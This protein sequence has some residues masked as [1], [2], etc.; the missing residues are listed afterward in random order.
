MQIV[1]HLDHLTLQHLLHFNVLLPQYKAVKELVFSL[2]GPLLLHYCLFS[3]HFH[4]IPTLHH[5]VHFSLKFLCYH[6]HLLE[7][8]FPP[9]V[10]CIPQ[11]VLIQNY[12][13]FF[14]SFT[15]VFTLVCLSTCFSYLVKDFLPNCLLNELPDFI[16]EI[17]P[18]LYV[19]GPRFKDVLLV[20]DF[21]VRVISP[22]KLRVS[23][24]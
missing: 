22:C 23:I 12:A 9:L 7:V 5:A 17:F 19:F 6:H 14:H 13:G 10:H 16:E 2:V 8:S 20:R 24:S 11:K 15:F 21:K 3:L 4:F 18:L 1:F